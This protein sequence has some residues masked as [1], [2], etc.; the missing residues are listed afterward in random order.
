[1]AC[2]AVANEVSGDDL[3]SAAQKDPLV[4]ELLALLPASLSASYL[5]ADVSWEYMSRWFKN[6]SEN[7]GFLKVCACLT[8]TRLM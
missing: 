6:K 8:L 5:H 4:A 3:R 2:W 7:F 1:M